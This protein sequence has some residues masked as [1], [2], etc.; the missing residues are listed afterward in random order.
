M[1]PFRD[2]APESVFGTSNSMAEQIELVQLV[3]SFTQQLFERHGDIE[4]LDAPRLFE[5]ARD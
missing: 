3:T 1:L 4:G 5:E 2:S